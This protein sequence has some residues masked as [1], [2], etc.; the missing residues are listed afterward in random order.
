[1]VVAHGGAPLEEKA[2]QLGLAQTTG[3]RRKRLLHSGPS[4]SMTY[5]VFVLDAPTH[6]TMPSSRSVYVVLLSI[7]RRGTASTA[8]KVFLALEGCIEARV[9]LFM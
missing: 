6:Q 9:R 5:D 4:S 7:T 1:M 3:G 8:E 2:D